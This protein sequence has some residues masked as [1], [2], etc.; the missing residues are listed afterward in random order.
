[1]PVISCTACP[2]KFK[3]ADSLVGKSVKCPKCKSVVKVPG[4]KETVGAGKAAAVAGKPA[5]TSSKPAA[6]AAAANGM[7]S[8]TCTCGKKLQV[9]EALAGKAVKCPGCAKPVKVPAPAPAGAGLDDEDWSNVEAEAPAPPARKGKAPAT[10]DEDEWLD[11]DEAAA[12]VED[13]DDEG[14]DEAPS[15]AGGGW[16]LLKKEKVPQDMIDEFRKELTKN[17]TIE[18]AARPRQD[19]LLHR[20]KRQAL[21]FG[22]IFGLVGVVALTAAVICAINGFWIGVAIG[23]VFGLVFSGGAI[24]MITQPGRVRKNEAKRPCFIMTQRRLLVHSGAGSVRVSVGAAAQQDKDYGPPPTGVNTY[25]GLDLLGLTRIDATGEFKGAGDLAFGTDLF[26][27]PLAPDMEALDKVVAIEKRIRDKLIHPVID[28]LLRG[29][30]LVKKGTGARKDGEGEDVKQDSNIKDYASDEDI[31]ED[32]P[33]IKDAPNRA[34]GLIAQFAKDLK[35]V[36]EELRD[37]VDAELTEGEKVLWIGE[38]EAGVKGRGLLGAMIGSAT[39]HEPKYT[40]YAITNRRVLLGI[41]KQTPVSYYPPSLMNTTVEQDKRIEKGGGII[42]RQVK[43]SIVTEDKKTGKVLSTKT[44]MHYFG[45]L[46]IRH[47]EKVA[48]LMYE[49]LVRPVKFEK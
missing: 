36:D 21:I 28:R 15:K 48:Q 22:S 2:T 20:A 39:R 33:N 37:E 17:E 27:V 4:G 44:E 10:D 47:Y 46:R 38:P 42:F 16:D 3:V 32:D 40:F 30:L 13:A 7:L 12:P 43:K 45:I 25:M 5:G 35:K 29:E 11:V 24:F 26:D 18:W 31:D 41:A 8:V 49:T 1:M 19:I 14:D 9:R 6:P 34:R 23:A